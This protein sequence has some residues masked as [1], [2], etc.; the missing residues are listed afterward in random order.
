MQR[1]ILSYCPYSNLM[2]PKSSSRFAPS[3]VAAVVLFALIVPAA[4]GAIRAVGKHKGDYLPAHNFKIEIDGVIAGGFKEISGLESEVE[5]IEFQGEDRLMHKRP[6]K[7]NYGNIVLKRGVTDGGD[8]I[9]QWYKKVLAGTTDRK[10]GSIIYL[11]RAGQEVLRYNFFEAWPCK[12]KLPA[13]ADNGSP[14]IEEIEICV[15]KIERE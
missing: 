4:H 14:A 8:D 6:G 15:E 12:W 1:Y 10:S 2:S 9:R 11:D 5:V 13:L 3:F 7:T